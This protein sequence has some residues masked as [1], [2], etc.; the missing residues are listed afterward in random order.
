MRLSVCVSACVPACVYV[1]VCVYS[2]NANGRTRTRLID[3]HRGTRDALGRYV[4]KCETRQ[5]RASRWCCTQVGG[6]KTYAHTLVLN[7]SMKKQKKKSFTYA[8]VNDRYDSSFVDVRISFRREAA[9][10]D[11]EPVGRQVSPV[12]GKPSPTR[13]VS[14]EREKAGRGMLYRSG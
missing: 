5:A 14:S 13:F 1:Y 2:K 4:A 3:S 7:I 12:V 10:I 11:I 8:S 6:R 9:E